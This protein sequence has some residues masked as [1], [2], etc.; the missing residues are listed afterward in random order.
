MNAIASGAL[1]LVRKQVLRYAKNGATAS[2]QPF[3]AAFELRPYVGGRRYG[4][5]HYGVMIADL[6]EPHRYLSVMVMAGLPGFRAFDV[7][8]AVATSPR[9]TATVAIS[10]AAK[11]AEHYHVVSMSKDCSLSSDGE[12]LRFG[13]E[14]HVSGRYPYV[15]V[16][17]QTDGLAAHLDFTMAPRATWFVKGLPYDH[18]SLLGDY[19]GSVEAG[20]DRL[21]VAG[22]GN[23]EYARCMGPYS[24]VDRPLAW[25]R[26]IPTDFFTYHVVNIAADTQLLFCRVGMFRQ[27]LGDIVQFRTRTG[28]GDWRVDD[29][30]SP[31]TTFF[32]V[33]EYANASPTDGCRHTMRLP[34]RIRFGVRDRVTVTGTYDCPPRYGVG[35]GYISGY[36]AEIELSGDVM[37]SRGYSEYVD[38]RD[39][40]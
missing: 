1:Q 27:R 39:W 11:A 19:T 14:L 24:V 9:D 33:L 34:H 16:D 38:V 20:T 18:L 3:D 22:L 8:D 25:N 31:A 2:V 17:I 23:I 13:T 10:T 7:D 29:V 15:S 35:H 30:A 37:A 28:S 4:W 26:K 32:E 40:N 12:D 5:T 6:P 36:R 21:E